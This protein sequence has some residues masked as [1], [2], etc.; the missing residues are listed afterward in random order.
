MGR[1]CKR[2]GFEIWVEGCWVYKDLR[3]GLTGLGFDLGNGFMRLGLVR[4][5]EGAKGFWA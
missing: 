2:F 5:D 1:V 3:C 4:W